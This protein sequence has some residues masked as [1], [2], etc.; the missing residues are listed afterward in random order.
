MPEPRAIHMGDEIYIGYKDGSHDA[1]S[2]YGHKPW[3]KGFEDKKR[4]AKE[5]NR[6]ER[7]KLEFAYRQDLNGEGPTF[8]LGSKAEPRVDSD[9]Y[10]FKN[11]Q[12]LKTI[13]KQ[14]RKDRR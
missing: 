14:Q 6:L 1:F 5:F 4:D 10:H 7:F 8:S 9:D 13:R 12:P 3:Q 11:M 2:A